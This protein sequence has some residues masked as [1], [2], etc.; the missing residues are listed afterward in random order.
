MISIKT[1]GSGSTGN[2][3]VLSD[4]HTKII[5]ECGLPFKEIAKALDYDFRNVSGCLITHEHAD[6]CKG[7]GG[8]TS[9]TSVSVLASVGTV[10][11]IKALDRF[12]TG[13]NDTQI[14]PMSKFKR[15]ELKGGWSVVAFDVTHEGNDPT[16]FLIES[17]D[18][19]KILFATDTSYIKY[20]FNDLTHII[21]EANYSEEILEQM[22]YH[23]KLKKRI[24]QTHFELD[25]VIRFINASKE[26]SSRLQHVFIVHTST[27]NGDPKAFQKKIQEETGIYTETALENMLKE[28]QQC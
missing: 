7:V 3:F 19:E 2:A 20:I 22:G 12:K 27:T 26:A 24:R 13:L 21:V 14:V 25:N 5:L 8:L 16:G 4:S 23:E 28:E 18:G 6:H 9:N 10:Q 17:K 11:G 1:I 15:Y